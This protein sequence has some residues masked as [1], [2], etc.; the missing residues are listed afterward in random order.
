VGPL[1]LADAK[2]PAARVIEVATHLPRRGA[3]LGVACGD[4]ACA[5]SIG[6]GIKDPANAAQGDVPPARIYVFLNDAG[7]TVWTDPESKTAIPR[8]DDGYDYQAFQEWLSAQNTTTDVLD[9]R[10]EGKPTVQDL[11]DLLDAAATSGFTL[12]LVAANDK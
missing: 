6:F 11:V 7:L 3:S 9:L 1:I 8:K 10:A 5:L 2:V 12:V 4:R